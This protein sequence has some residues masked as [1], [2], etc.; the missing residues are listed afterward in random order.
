[1]FKAELQSMSNTLRKYYKG[2]Y[3]ERFNRKQRVTKYPRKFFGE[4]V[5]SFKEDD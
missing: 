2:L 4:T 5:L 3:Q 1:M